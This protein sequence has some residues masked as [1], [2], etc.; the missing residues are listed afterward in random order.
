MRRATDYYSWCG[1]A[2]AMN[3]QTTTATFFTAGAPTKSVLVG[4]SCKITQSSCPNFPSSTGT[5]EDIWG[6]QH[7]GASVAPGA[8]MQA[9]HRLL[10]LVWRAEGDVE[11]HDH[12]GFFY[13]G[14]EN[15]H[16][17]SRRPGQSEM[18]RDV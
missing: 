10:Q 13:R 18:S 15:A 1:G 14:R 6:D 11:Q 9:C 2:S 7:A 5:F 17:H 3:G 16:D 4:N 8:C 12:S